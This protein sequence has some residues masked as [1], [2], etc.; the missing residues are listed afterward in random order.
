MPPLL[1]L[2]VSNGEIVRHAFSNLQSFKYFYT[3]EQ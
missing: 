3:A 2:Y 1:C